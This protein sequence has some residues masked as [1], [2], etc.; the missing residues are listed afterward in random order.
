MLESIR[1]ILCQPQ[2]ERVESLESENAE[3][4]DQIDELETDVSDAR[5]EI[6]ALESELAEATDSDKPAVDPSVAGTVVRV[7]RAS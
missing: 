3:L 1:S 2:Q 6:Q 5:S 4:R 7:E